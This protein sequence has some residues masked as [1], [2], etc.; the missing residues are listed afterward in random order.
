VRHTVAAAAAVLAGT[1]ALTACSG[2]G[3]DTGGRASAAPTP[4]APA[5]ASTGGGS[6]A[7]S[8]SGGGLAGTWLA[9]TGGKAVV[10]VI[11][12]TEAGVFTTGGTVCSGSAGTGPTPA[13]RL[14]CT[15][16]STDRASGTVGSVGRNT[17]EVTWQSG[18]GRETYTRSEDGKLPTALP[19]AGLGS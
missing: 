6:D 5:T 9:T 10:L 18:L 19:T 13:I 11:T 3:D 1:L 16:G 2:D 8:A 4:S 7:P 12:G 14:K 15:D 17:L